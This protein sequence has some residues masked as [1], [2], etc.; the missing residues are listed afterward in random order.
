LFEW[1]SEYAVDEAL[2]LVDLSDPAMRAISARLLAS[3]GETRF[4]SI[5]EKLTRDPINDVREAIAR[6]ISHVLEYERRFDDALGLALYDFMRGCALRTDKGPGHGFATAMFRLDRVRAAS[7]LTIEESLTLDRT[8]LYDI[9]G[10]IYKQQLEIRP[11]LVAKLLDD[12]VP[13]F[14]REGVGYSVLSSTCSA[15]TELICLLA[16]YDRASAN[17]RME[18]LRSHTQE[19]AREAAQSARERLSPDPIRIVLKAHEAAAGD[20]LSIRREYRVVY[21]AWLLAAEVGN[22]GWLQWAANPSGAYMR[23]TLDALHE[24]GACAAAKQL[25][26]M[27]NALGSDGWSPVQSKRM[28]SIDRALVARR[29]LPDD[30]IMWKMS[31]DLNAMLFD[32]AELHHDAFEK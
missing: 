6:G 11:A 27:M 5:L 13:V 2:K 26:V 15:V 30:G 3:T 10:A 14:D 28:A 24:I 23:E 16:R 32:Y 1:K 19:K 25:Q 4:A 18:A 9:L 12:A 8:W 29:P 17:S 22:G 7:D 20:V 21:L 31:T